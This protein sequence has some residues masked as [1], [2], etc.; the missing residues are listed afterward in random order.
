[1]LEEEH[2]AELKV[3]FGLEITVKP[4]IKPYLFLLLAYGL[5]FDYSFI[6]EVRYWN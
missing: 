3:N 6:K 1:M 2:M 4:P 5:V